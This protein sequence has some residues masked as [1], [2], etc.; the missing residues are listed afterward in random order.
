MPMIRAGLR[1]LL[2]LVS[3]SFAQRRAVV[4]L[5]VLLVVIVAVMAI[6]VTTAAPVVLYPFI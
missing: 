2:D 1:V 6:T 5:A 4:L 3:F